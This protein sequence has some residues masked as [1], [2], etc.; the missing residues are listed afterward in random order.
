MSIYSVG[1]LTKVFQGNTMT[2]TTVTLASSAG[3]VVATFISAVYMHRVG[4]KGF[5]LVSTMGMTV[6]AVFLVIGSASPNAAQL[7]P[8]SITACK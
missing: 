6:G 8:L 4:R 5:M 1:F 2:A 7:A 3:A